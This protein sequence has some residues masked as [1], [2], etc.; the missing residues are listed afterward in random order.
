MKLGPLLPPGKKMAAA[1]PASRDRYLDALRTAALFFVVA[2][3]ALMLTMTAWPPGAES[4][5]IGNTL[6]SFPILQIFTWVLQPMAVF[7]FAGGAANLAAMKAGETKGRTYNQWLWSRTARLYKPVLVYLVVNILVVVPV[8]MALGPAGQLLLTA[9]TGLFWFVAVYTATTALLPL[10]NR[11]HSKGP[12]IPVVVMFASIALVDFARRGLGVSDAIGI[13]NIVLVW[14]LFQQFGSW[15]ASGM[16]TR[17]MNAGLTVVGLAGLL[18]TTQILDYPMSMVGTAAAGPSNTVPPSVALAFQG[19][20]LIGL[21]GLA[22]PAIVG[23][24][25][26]QRIWAGVCAA[27]ACAMTL[28]LWHLPSLVVA[29]SIVHYSGWF[30]QAV[31][32]SG[33][34]PMPGAGFLWYEAAVLSLFAALT[35]MLVAVFWRVELLRL[36]W[37]DSPVPAQGPIANWLRILLTTVAVAALTFGVLVLGVV[38]FAGFPLAVSTWAGVPL[39]SGAS[40]LLCAGGILTLRFLAG[41]RVETATAT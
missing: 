14:L 34:M 9:I 13:I 41:R 39:N 3:H 36:P 8:A 30:P 4:P 29:M 2:G 12:Y 28:Y 7:F 5:T 32:M 33:G 25:E 37:W 6:D 27:S 19:V 11:W 21:V 1:S 16:L 26:N 40:L 20:F 10:M 15:Y 22:K 17:K 23:V 31:I 35:F 38:G 18:L 24:L